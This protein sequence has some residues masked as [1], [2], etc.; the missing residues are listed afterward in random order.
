MPAP[1][2]QSPFSWTWNPCA[3]GASP[4]TRAVTTTLSPFWTKL[5]VPLA[6]LPFVGSSVATAAPPEGA[7]DAQA[8]ANALRAMIH[9]GL[10]MDFLLV[11]YARRMV[12]HADGRAGQSS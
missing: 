2:L 7:I 11:V 9:A 4:V 10:R 1:G 5:T 8:A 6:A 12:E 3:P